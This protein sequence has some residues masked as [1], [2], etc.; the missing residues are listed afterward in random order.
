MR[1]KSYFPPDSVCP[2]CGRTFIPAPYHIY[3]AY[4]NGS[5]KYLCSWTCYCKAKGKNK[6]WRDGKGG[7]KNGAQY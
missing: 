5:L 6:R 2:I 3:K 4:I 1:K 7:G